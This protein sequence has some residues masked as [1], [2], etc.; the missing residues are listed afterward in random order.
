MKKYAFNLGVIT[1]NP[2]FFWHLK[3]KPESKKSNCITAL[4]RLL[5]K[6]QESRNVDNI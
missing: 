3:V 6:T 1:L 5:C 4:H 2:R